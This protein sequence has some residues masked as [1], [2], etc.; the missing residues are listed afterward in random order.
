MSRPASVRPR[1]VAAVPLALLLVGCAKSPYDLALDEAQAALK[2]GDVARA[3][4]NFHR[5]CTLKP[6][7]QETCTQAK[8]TFADLKARRLPPATQACA[9]PDIDA[10]HQQI[11]DVL[12]VQGAD[13]DGVRLVTQGLDTH[14]TACKAQDTGPFMAALGALKCMQHGADVTKRISAVYVAS[15]HATAKRF[16]EASPSALPGASY[17]LLH[18][19]SCLQK[20]LGAETDAIARETLIAAAA[21]PIA[22]N[23]RD[24]GP[25]PL[26]PNITNLCGA[27]A[28]AMGVRA[29]CGI[30][31]DKVV[32][33]D[34]A[35]SLGRTVDNVTEELRVARYVAGTE[36][37]P[38]PD[39]A[40][41]ERELVRT[42][43]SFEQIDREQR[44][45]E[46]NCAA[47][48]VATKRTACAARDATVGEH[49]RR[50]QAFQNAQ[51][52]VQNTPP[53][54]DREIIK[55]VSFTVRHH[56]WSTAWSY[57][58][59]Q[60]SR[61]G[62]IV[63]RD[64][65]H[66][67]VPVANVPAD[68]LAA[69]SREIIEGQ[70]RPALLAAAQARFEPEFQGKVARCAQAPFNFDDGPTLDCRVVAEFLGRGSPPAPEAWMPVPCEK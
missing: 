27:V 34:V 61:Q 33:F 37:V 24:N 18:T 49:T 48:P 51:S 16:L 6:G 17:A 32:S 68:P 60:G 11:G 1:L 29:Q 55:E 58:S 45:N 19:A 9:T 30:R 2:A 25:T 56:T 3:A 62:T 4:L 42:R 14:A 70:L 39:Y 69:P 57:E 10:C 40:P 13:P 12:A 54:I 20:S 47:A 46:A 53:T 50:Q 35:V 28:Q 5:A 36:R 43:S 59:P 15:R 22:V 26:S 65:E 44:Q 31:T 52:R 8:Q 23:V 67:A 64:S 7:E 63:F 38:N 21:T 41:A 66:P